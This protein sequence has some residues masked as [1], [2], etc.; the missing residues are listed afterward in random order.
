MTNK[1]YAL[2]RENLRPTKI[3]TADFRGL[4]QMLLQKG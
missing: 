1:K 4:I 2:I 3:L